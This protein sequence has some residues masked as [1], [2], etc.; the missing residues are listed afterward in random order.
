MTYVTG[1]SQTN[2]QEIDETHCAFQLENASNINHICVFL[3]GTGVRSLSDS[4]GY[5]NTADTSPISTWLCSHCSF[6]LARQRLPIARNVSAHSPFPHPTLDASPRLSNEKPSAIFR[7]RG[8][9][10]ASGDYAGS[11]RFTQ[12]FQQQQTQA[13][14]PGST[15]SE[16]VTALL[17]IAIEPV[18]SV[19]SQVSTLSSS[20]KS[21][22]DPT[23][24]AERIARHLL[25][26]TSSFGTTSIPQRA[27]E[28]WYESFRGK[29]LAMGTSFLERAD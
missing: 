18:D 14:I 4:I 2:L 8:T 10:G 5:T 22:P 25:N 13:I 17:G 3:L 28:Q 29:V 15:A 16:N 12:S 7:V 1:D 21:V 9:F 26:F 20:G 23:V 24:L 19:I 27:I 6:F 11:Q